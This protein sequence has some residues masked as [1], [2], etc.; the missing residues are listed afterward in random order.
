MVALFGF[1]IAL[2]LVVAV[3]SIDLLSAVRSYVTGESLYSKGQKDAQIHLIDYAEYH[4][5]EDYRR[6][7]E[8]LA[9]PLGDRV[10]RA[11]SS[12]RSGLIRRSL[13]GLFWTAAITPTIS[14][15]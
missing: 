6:F 11:R 5:E 8:A 9:V 10:A 13:E 15:A 14:P 3:V 1:I 4:R 12:R 7:L 2:Q